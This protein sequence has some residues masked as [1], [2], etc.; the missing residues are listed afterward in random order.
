MGDRYDQVKEQIEKTTLL[1]KTSTPEDI[2]RTIVHLIEEAPMT[3]GQI[4]VLD[5]GQLVNQGRL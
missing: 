5:G 4:L 1:D 2:G 3:T